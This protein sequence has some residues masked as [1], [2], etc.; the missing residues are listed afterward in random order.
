MTSTSLRPDG[1][2]TPTTVAAEIHRHL[3]ET[4][5]LLRRE[6]KPISPE[7][8]RVALRGMS[9]L[10]RLAFERGQES[11][12]EPP[13]LFRNDP[14]VAEALGMWEQRLRAAMAEQIVAAGHH[15]RSG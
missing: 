12:A 7:L 3:A 4:A 9:E 10:C 5:A 13:F 6:P 1:Q 11:P 15:P 2:S 14:V 8:L